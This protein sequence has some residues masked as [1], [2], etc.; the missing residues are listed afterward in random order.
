MQIELVA[1]TP[2]SLSRGDR[3]GRERAALVVPYRL[4]GDR[5][6]G[7]PLAGENR[8]QRFDGLVGADQ[9][10]GLDEL[11]EQ[12]AAEQPVV[13]ELLVAAFE[14]RDVRLPIGAAR[15]LG[16]EIEALEQIGPQI[17]HARQ[18][19]RSSSSKRT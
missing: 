7:A 12:L 10:G 11:A 13:L 9:A 1:S 14:H 16:R 19:K 3:Q 8:V 18:C 2:R 5:F 4:V 15:R 6:V 17:G